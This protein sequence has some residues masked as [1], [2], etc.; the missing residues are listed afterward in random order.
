MKKIILLLFSLYAIEAKPQF[1]P[2]AGT[3]GTSA[4]AASSGVF[5]SWASACAVTRGLQDKSNPSLNYTTVGSEISA[6]GAA[7]QDGVVSLGDG[8]SAILTFPFAISDGPG[9]DFAVFENAFNDSFLELA[10][11]EVSSDGTNF[12]RFPSTSLSQD[13]IQFENDAEMDP[14]KINNL[15]GKYR[16]LYGTPFDLDEL[17]GKEGLDIS[18]VTHVKIIDVTG[19]LNPEFANFD[20]NGHRINDP[21]PTPFASCGFDLDAVGVID[22]Q[23]MDVMNS[24]SFGA[25]DLFQNSTNDLVMLKFNEVIETRKLKVVL[26]DVHGQE[27]FTRYKNSNQRE[28]EISL[29]NVSSGIYFILIEGD[30]HSYIK[31]IT[32]N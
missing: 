2:G 29:N 16:A 7:G 26:K 19:S 10:F 31:K 18:N 28:M 17:K 25:F 22:H 24:T 30:Q 8:G 9:P 6:I 5:K 23:L 32:K 27:L 11:V 3:P 15:A 21:W 14:R 4:I 20:Q 13:T 12:F 1:A